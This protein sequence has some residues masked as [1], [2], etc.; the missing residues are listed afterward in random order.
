MVKKQEENPFVRGPYVQMAA[1]CERVLHEADGVI[2][3]IRVVDR[4][5]HVERGSAAPEE[6]PEV[7][8]PLT[9]VVTLKS[10]S[11]RG[12]HELTFTPQLPDGQ[13]LQPITMTIQMEGEQ[14][15]V[16]IISQ[17]DIP[18]KLEGLYWFVISFDGQPITRVPLEIQYS[19]LVTGSPRP[20][21]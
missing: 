21:P 2:S 15:G 16:N 20:Q 9:L 3:L 17:I 1:F 5:T 13:K 4:I 14:R 7:H 8:Y 18:Y 6:M 12:R 10:G 11:A 19:R